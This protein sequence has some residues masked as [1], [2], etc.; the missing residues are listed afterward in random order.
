MD[1]GFGMINK[2]LEQRGLTKNTIVIF[3]GDNGESL[4]RGKGTLYDRGTH[5]RR[6]HNVLD[7]QTTTSILTGGLIIGIQTG[8]RH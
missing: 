7:A 6:R 3:M 8:H 2:L 1:R 5:V 4:L